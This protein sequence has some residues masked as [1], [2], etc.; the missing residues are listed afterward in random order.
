MDAVHEGGLGGTY[1]GNPVAAAAALAAIEV[2][3]RDDLAKRARSIG[4]VARTRLDALALETPSIGEVRGRG[5]MIGIEFV[6]PG[7]K[8]PYAAAVKQVIAACA[9]Q[10]VL[11]ISCG[12]FGNVIRLLPPLSI[13]EALLDDGLSVLESAIRDLQD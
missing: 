1:G 9:A 6:E 10:G 13:S 4:E 8:A 3:R 7:T 2:M 12:T 11:V 5:A